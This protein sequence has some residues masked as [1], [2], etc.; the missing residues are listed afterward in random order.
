VDRVAAGCR[1]DYANENLANQLE[2]IPETVGTRG[3]FLVGAHAA[4]ALAH[5]YMRRDDTLLQM[6]PR[7]RRS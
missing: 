3:Y 5:H 6:L 4:A 7:W 2:E 1:Q